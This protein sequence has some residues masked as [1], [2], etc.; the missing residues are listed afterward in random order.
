MGRFSDLL[1]SICL[2]TLLFFSTVSLGQA[3]EPLK[4][5]RL[6][7]KWVHQF[8]FA[9][10]YAAKEKGF[11]RE[12]GLDVAI[13]QRN[14]NK[15]NIRQVLE[16]EAEY[17]IADSI[18][19]LYRMRGEPVVLLAP[20]FQHSPLIY[21]TLR[22]SGIESPYQIKGKRVMVY[23]DD[24][25]GLPLAGMLYQLDIDK[26][27]F[28]SIPKTVNPDA[29]EKGVVD[30]YP[31]Y[32]TNEP[33]YFYSRGVKINIINPKNYGA[34]LYGDMLFTSKTELENHPDRAERFR[35]AS[36]KGWKYALKHPDEIIDVIIQ[37][38][39]VEKS[40][41]HLSYEADIIRQMIIN[42]SIS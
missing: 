10:Y 8:Q 4:K 35:R 22:S 2:A 38:Y 33:F 9:G 3:Q 42:F 20:I 29:L 26:D 7:L 12:E 36:L 5:V 27:S 31:G 6:Q 39:G 30:V 23:P 40:R 28:T 37:K 32:L 34:D 11:Y 15:N 19:L 17:G 25:D 16:G 24:T 41:E 21:M 18:L 13:Q 14:P 1:K